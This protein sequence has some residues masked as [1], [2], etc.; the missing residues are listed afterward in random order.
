MADFKDSRSSHVDSVEPLDPS[1]EDAY[2]RANY[3][4][5]PYASG[6]PYDTFRPA[7]RFGWES[8]GRHPGRTF[9]DVAPELQH[10][11]EHTGHSARLGW[12]RARNAIRDAWHKLE[13]A[14]PGDFD[15]D[16]R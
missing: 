11:W 12:A 1:T 14:L 7:Y 15:K 9:E 4:V 6:E 8:Y 13:R 10:D 16:G 5:R 2:W 3:M